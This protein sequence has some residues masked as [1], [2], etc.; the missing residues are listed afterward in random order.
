MLGV[1]LEI[2]IWILN[3]FDFDNNSNMKNDFIEYMK[4]SCCLSF[5]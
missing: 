2:D 4:K 5:A 1:S 3:S